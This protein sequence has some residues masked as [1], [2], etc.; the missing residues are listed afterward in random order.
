MIFTVQ[1]LI[2]DKP[3][4]Q[5]FKDNVRIIAWKLPNKMWCH[6]FFVGIINADEVKK[7]VNYYNLLFD[8]NIEMEQVNQVVDRCRDENNK[9]KV[10]DIVGALSKDI[11]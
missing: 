11:V 7:I 3:L 9:V 10:D 5:C 4:L 1:K 8:S 2:L 6:L